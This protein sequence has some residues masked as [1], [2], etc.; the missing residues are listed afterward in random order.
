MEDSEAKRRKLGRVQW[1]ERKLQKAETLATGP[2]SC[3]DLGN[4]PA[5][6]V[7]A[8]T[9]SEEDA[10][11]VLRLRSH[12]LRGMTVYTDY[13]GIDCPREALSLCL[14]ALQ[15]AQ[16]WSVEAPAKF[17][18]SCDISSLAREVL[19][20][21]AQVDGGC[22]F[23]DILGRLPPIAQ[24]WIQSARPDPDAT[25]EVARAAYATIRQWVWDNREWLF[26]DD[27]RCWCEKHA[28]ACAAHPLLS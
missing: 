16:G 25:L 14:E 2:E 23:G 8:L 27:A 19:L 9:S 24:A 1:S 18:R 17:V 10:E 6:V 4:W 28:A 15:A 5:T 3:E 13:S 21:H 20:K 26:P 22:V 7:S 12:V 11:I